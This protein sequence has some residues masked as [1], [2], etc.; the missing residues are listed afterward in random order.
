MK[1]NKIEEAKALMNGY[2]SDCLSQKRFES[3]NA[4]YRKNA[5][6]NDFSDERL[7]ILGYQVD[8]DKSKCSNLAI[9][10]KD[11]NDKFLFPFEFKINDNGVLTK[12]G[13]PPDP[14]NR[15]NPKKFLRRMGW[16]IV[17]Y[18]LNN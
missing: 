2:A 4:E 5:R 17:G 11:K 14:S 15:I 9:K 6:P 3:D 8:G 13:T 18:L 12:I 1:L 10:P 7:G 16:K